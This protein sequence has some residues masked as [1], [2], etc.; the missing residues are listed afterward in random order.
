MKKKSLIL[1][2]LS[3]FLLVLVSCG[4]DENITVFSNGETDYSIIIGS[5]ASEEEKELA[6]AL[7]SLSANYK[8]VETDEA[9]EVSKEII[10]GGADRAVTAEFINE[11]KSYAGT[12]VF[13]Y[14]IA[15]SDGKLVI[16]AD[17][18]EGYIYALTYIKENYISGNNLTVPKDICEVKSVLWADYYASDLYYDRLTQAADK[19][20]Y[21]EGKDH[22]NNEMNRYEDINGNPI[23]TVKEAIEYYRQLAQNFNTSDFGEYSPV[24]FISKNSYGEPTFYPETSHPRIMF[25]ENSIDTLRENLTAAQNSYA[26]RRYIALSDAPCDGKFQVLTSTMSENYDGGIVGQIE[27]KA[28][29]YAMTGEEIYG[30]QAIYAAK[31]AMLTLDVPFTLSDACRRYG[32]LMYVTA[33]VYDWCYDLL[34][35][36]DKLQLVNGCV[37]ILGK[38]QEIVRYN[39][40]PDNKA[41][42]EQGVYH[43]HG[44]EDQL[45]VDYLAFAIACYDENP[46]IYDL[47]A[48]RILNDYTEAQ[49]YIFAS[50]SHGEGTNYGVHRGMATIV[51]NILFNRMTDGKEMPFSDALEDIA[52]TAT[53]YVRPDDQPFRIGDMNENNTGYKWEGLGAFCFYVGS[54]YENSYLKSVGYKYLDNFTYFSNYTA[55][56]SVVQFLAVND[57]ELSH[58]YE[59]ELPLTHTTGIGTMPD[60]SPVWPDR[61]IFAKSANGDENA[62]ALYM[63]MPD[64]Y[65]AGH[66]HMECGSFQIF[67]KGILASDSGHYSTWG[68]DHH[69]GYATQT[70]A[71]NSLIVFN[72]NLVGTYNDYRNTLVYT[73]GQ[74]IKDCGRLPT[75]LEDHVSYPTSRNWCETLGT[76]NAELNGKYL[77]SYMGGDM[78][79]AYDEET[80]DEVTRYMFAVATDDKA[81]P[82]VFITFDR[83][84]SDDASFHKA[85]LIHTQEEP[86]V[87]DDGFAIITNTKNGNSGKM[88]VQSVGYATNYDVIGGEGKEFWIAGV[89]K[90]GCYSLADGYN[91]PTNV[92]LVEN[93]IAE[94]GWGRIEIS[95]AEAEKTNHMLTVMYVTDSSNDSSP[96]RAEQIASDKLSGAMIF[97]KAVLFPTNDKL[98]GDEASFTVTK[99]GE[100]FVAGVAA[101]TWT[102]M[103]GN[104]AVATAE[105]A[106]GAN[107]LTF[108]AENAGTYTLVPQN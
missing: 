73:G 63:T 49:N 7:V 89:D 85:A 31:N 78:T 68:G 48:G 18:D 75:K 107:L 81:C 20:R 102:V 100:C 46:E 94:Y 21:E 62:F 74:S 87:T 60:G 52:I 44:S 36:T 11:L 4:S 32:A 55:S 70:V 106:D 61:N 41:P 40:D 27:A 35:E 53:Y 19:D 10:I 51:S 57:P 65:M 69:F 15:E 66:A 83:I 79:N 104:T 6:E 3:V 97:D 5:E 93:S 1:I 16:L 101:G 67:Y 33:C 24:E 23:M 92:K 84:T 39:S 8:E 22:F 88:I 77:Y 98:L 71:S 99:S 90:E 14:M 86:T 43:G 38:A 108:T 72:P 37:N 96:E 42:I 12:S 29:R 17:R 13:H 59:E 34:S 105:V 91:K 47:C 9:P 28:F 103:K 54:L 50:G 26:Y 2:L 76:V 64:Y 58:I 30:Y 45:L 82:L 80:V 56:L 95:P 25:T